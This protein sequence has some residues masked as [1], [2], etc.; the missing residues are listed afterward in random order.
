VVVGAGLPAAAAVTKY[1]PLLQ[2]LRVPDSSLAC[3]KRVPFS[4]AGSFP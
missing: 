2:L 3:R 4:W 1:R